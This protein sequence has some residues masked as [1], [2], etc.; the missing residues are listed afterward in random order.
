[1]YFLDQVYSQRLQNRKLRLEALD[2]TYTDENA[3]LLGNTTPPSKTHNELSILP[4]NIITTTKPVC[5]DTNKTV[6]EQAVLQDINLTRDL[7]MGYDFIPEPCPICFEIMWRDTVVVECFYCDK[8][9]CNNCYQKIE[10]TN[11]ERHLP[12]TCPLCRGIYVN[13]ESDQEAEN[14]N[15][16]NILQVDRQ[17]RRHHHRIITRRKGI[18]KEIFKLLIAISIV[19]FIFI[20]LYPR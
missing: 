10:Q 11:H 16:E 4:P 18:L 7:E 17:Q 2:P 19:V 12:N 6:L 8:K 1:M 15:E 13:Y 14:E 3:Y 9:Y 5:N 20:M